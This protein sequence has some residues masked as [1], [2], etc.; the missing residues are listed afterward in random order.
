MI[1]FFFYYRIRHP[2][3]H[4]PGSHQTA[5]ARAPFRTPASLP[6][7]ERR[8]RAMSARGLGGTAPPS[9]DPSR[10]TFKEHF[11]SAVSSAG[12][13]LT[14]PHPSWELGNSFFF[15]SW[16]GRTRFL[17]PAD[18]HNAERPDFQSTGSRL[19]EVKD[20]PAHV[21]L[22]TARP[23]S[24]LGRERGVSTSAVEPYF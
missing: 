1:F 19:R 16:P 5:A 21:L 9:A 23:P 13:N 4:S 2:S 6:R 8:G 22:I 14:V 12:E 18:A 7:T 15:L 24:V 17:C 10:G 11:M 3:I 20:R